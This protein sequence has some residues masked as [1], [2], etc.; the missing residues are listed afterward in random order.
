MSLNATARAA[1]VLLVEDNLGDIVLI[2]ELLGAGELGARLS[3][4]R[5]GEEA[6][7]FLRQGGEYAAAPRPDL[8]LLDLNL[9]RK[10]GCE[11]LAEL[12]NG[13]IVATDSGGGLDELELT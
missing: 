12:K 1:E 8:I 7:R 13:L 2:K 10:D 6:L 3:V 11:L 4:V 5:D 9:P